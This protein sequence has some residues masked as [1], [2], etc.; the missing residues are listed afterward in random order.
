MEFHYDL[1]IV[2]ATGRA[3]QD[4][5]EVER[6]AD[7]GL[8]IGLADGVSGMSGGIEAATQ[9]VQ[10]WIQQKSL[11]PELAL[12]EADS[13]L[14]RAPHGGQTTS[15]FLELT[16]DGLRGASVGDSRVWW[17]EA[18]GTWKELTEHQRPR[19]YL[20][21][22][23]A[24]PIAFSRIP[25]ETGRLLICSDGLWRYA[26]ISQILETVREQELAAAAEL[27]VAAPQS[28]I[29]QDYLDD[30][31]FVLVGWESSVTD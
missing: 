24:V 30:V 5:A 22:G 25:R 21:S 29:S 15:I 3:C 19:P 11:A 6:L 18:N 10:S 7:G 14:S 1:R 17:L 27:L 31:S 4:Y 8:R 2:A 28:P 13:L 16:A 9:A 20:G 26:G 23:A 12:A